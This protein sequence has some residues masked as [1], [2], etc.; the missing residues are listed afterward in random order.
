M[1]RARLGLF[2]SFKYCIYFIIELDLFICFEVSC[3]KFWGFGICKAGC[4]G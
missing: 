1:N 4:I 2:L 3:C